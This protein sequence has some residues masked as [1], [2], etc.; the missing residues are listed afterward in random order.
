MASA[1]AGRAQEMLSALDIDMSFEVAFGAN[2]AVS[3]IFSYVPFDVT[4]STS[5]VPVRVLFVII[6]FWVVVVVIV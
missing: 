1:V 5:F 3:T 4:F 2:K 6:W